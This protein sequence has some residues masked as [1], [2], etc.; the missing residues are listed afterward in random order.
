MT[1]VTFQA[2][3]TDIVRAYRNGALDANDQPA[4]RVTCP[5]DGAAPCRHCLNYIPKGAQMLILAHKPFDSAQ[6]YAES[7]PIFLCAEECK[8]WEGDGAPPVVVD[9]KEDR[10]VKGYSA[11]DRIIYGLGKIVAPQEV[12]DRARTV[13]NDPRTAYVHIRSSTNNCFT[14][15]VDPS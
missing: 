2:L 13:L 10:L 14:C 5:E 1:D 12:A 3:P 4:E 6:P 15:R 7:G 11:D 8:R 9:S